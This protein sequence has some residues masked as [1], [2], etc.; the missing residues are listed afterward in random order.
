[1]VGGEPSVG[2]RR[3]LFLQTTVSEDKTHL[4]STPGL[5]PLYFAVESGTETIDNPLHEA[6]KR[7][8]LTFLQECL[9]NRVSHWPGHMVVM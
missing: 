8:N 7:G 4:I 9:D 6:A 2:G 5:S 1:M 3:D